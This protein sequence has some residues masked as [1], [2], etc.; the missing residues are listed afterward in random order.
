MIIGLKCVNPLFSDKL[1]ISNVSFENNVNN[2]T[3]VTIKTI[4]ID[5]VLNS[6]LNLHDSLQFSSYF[7]HQN[8]MSLI[9]YK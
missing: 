6:N 3:S 1:T 4:G 5:T 8:L 2:I 9:I 7:N